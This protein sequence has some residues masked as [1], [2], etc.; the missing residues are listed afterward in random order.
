MRRSV[1]VLSMIQAVTLVVLLS[2]ETQADIRSEIENCLCPLVYQPVCGS[3][4]VTYDECLLYCA[5]ATPTGSRIALKKLH[6]GRCENTK[7]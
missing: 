2:A 7:L 4:N 5:M 6:D 3:D 1:S